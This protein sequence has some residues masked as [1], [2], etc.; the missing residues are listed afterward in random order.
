MHLLYCPCNRANPLIINIIAASMIVLRI[1]ITD[2]MTM[3]VRISFV[4]GSSFSLNI[5]VLSCVLA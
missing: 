5:L 3:I 2:N 1:N 4:R